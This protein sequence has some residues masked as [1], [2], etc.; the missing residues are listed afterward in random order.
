[1]RSRPTPRRRRAPASCAVGREADLGGNAA[2]GARKRARIAV[3][4]R[5]SCDIGHRDRV[6]ARRR[7]DPEGRRAVGHPLRRPAAGPARGPRRA[8]ERPILVHAILETAQGVANVEEIATA[9][10]RMQGISLGPAD[11]AASRRMKTTRVGGGHPGYRVLADPR[12]QRASVLPAGPLALH[13][14]PHGRRL[15]GRRHLPVLRP[16][17]RHQGRRGLRGPVPRRLP[18][19]LRRHLVAAPGADRDRQAGLL[20]RPGRGGVRA[21]GARGDPRRR[22][23]CT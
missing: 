5:R 20:A 8:V 1:M 4:A 12:R 14:R 10:P 3:G 13:D 21:Q 11:L 23:A 16:V 18:D 7:D 22:A 17:R 9:S 6:R 2:V 15:R 19:G